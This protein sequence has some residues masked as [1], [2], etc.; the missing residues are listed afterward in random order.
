[1]ANRGRQTDGKERRGTTPAHGELWKEAAIN[2]RE[3]ELEPAPKRW[4]GIV[5]CCFRWPR[6]FAAFTRA[7]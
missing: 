2:Q 6:V 7:T 1:M 3:A 5:H 4:I